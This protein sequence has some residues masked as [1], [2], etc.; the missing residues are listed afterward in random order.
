MTLDY[1]GN[2]VGQLD[3]V[4][5]AEDGEGEDAA[6]DGFRIPKGLGERNQR[7]L[8]ATPEERARGVVRVPKCVVCPKAGFSKLENIIRHCDRTEAHPK[9]LVFCRFC[10]VFFFNRA[11]KHGF[12]TKRTPLKC[13]STLAR[14]R[15]RKSGG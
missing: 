15:L 5:T 4:N 8:T 12:D 7:L 3:G 1:T 10:G 14:P 6:K 2:V 13:A 11:Q 9:S